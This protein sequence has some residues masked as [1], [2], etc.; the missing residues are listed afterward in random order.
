MDR[1]L[2]VRVG[3]RSRPA[4]DRIVVGCFSGELPAVESLPLELRKAALRLARRPG[5]KAQEG[6]RAE[7]E[8]GGFKARVL[9]LVSWGQREELESHSL[10]TLLLRLAEEA[11]VQGSRRPS[12]VL[13]VHRETEGEVAGARIRR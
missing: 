9:E 2:E 8:V 3:R 7:C 12:I 4:G 1:I 11:R 13:P 10:R 5:W 6:Q